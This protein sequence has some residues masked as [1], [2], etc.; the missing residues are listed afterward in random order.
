MS[1]STPHPLLASSPGAYLQVLNRY[2]CDPSY[3]PTVLGMGAVILARKPLSWISK[4]RF[5]R[6][7]SREELVEDPLIVVGHWRSGTTHLQNLLCQDPQFGCVP[8]LQAAIPHEALLCSSGIRARLQN[9]LPATRLMDNLPVSIDVPW[10]EELALA[11]FSRFSYY[12]ISSFPREMDQ[13]F[14][15]TVLLEEASLQDQEA[16]WKHTHRFLQQVQM[17]H[18]GKPLML[19]DPAN[20]ARVRLLR[21]HLP[22]ARFLHLHRNPYEVFAS[23]VHLHEKAQAAWGLQQGSRDMIVEHVLSSYPKLMQAW[24]DQKD[25]IPDGHLAEM[26]FDDLIADPVRTLRSAYDELGLTGFDTALPRMEAYLSEQRNY[27][28]NRLRLSETERERIAREW[29]PWFER[30]GYEC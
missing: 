21:S 11:A 6:R 17:Q 29:K 20:T 22:K 18:P 19:K 2:G 8:L 27:Q 14:Q 12:H 13:V 5:G 15:D 7:I 10:E 23:T 3:W 4:L 30:L 16:W 9:S 26:R 25:G 1:S 28:K 24:F